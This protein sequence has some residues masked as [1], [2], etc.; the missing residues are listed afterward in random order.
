MVFYNSKETDTNTINTFDLIRT[1]KYVTEESSR[2]C[3]E[4]GLI[5]LW[6]L[7]KTY[8]QKKRSKGVK[9]KKKTLRNNNLKVS[10]QM[11]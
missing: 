1:V 3:V 7:L 9:F 11:S 8:W 6:L 5:V 4:G 10:E 2:V